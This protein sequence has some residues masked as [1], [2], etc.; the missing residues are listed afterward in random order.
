MTLDEALE[1]HRGGR[2]AQAEACYRRV[3]E[4]QPENVDALHLLG[5]IAYQRGEH[6]QAERLIARALSLNAANAPAHSNLGNV[7]REQGRD[8]EAVAAYRRALALAPDYLEAHLNLGAALVAQDRLEEAASCYRAVQSIAP[9]SPTGHVHLGHIMLRRGAAAEALRCYEK[10]LELGLDSAVLHKNLGN[11]LVALGRAEDAER[12]YAR[13]LELDPDFAA[14]RLARGMTRLMLGDYETGLALLESR[15]DPRAL[16]DPAYEGMQA[17]AARIMQWPRWRGEPLPG[18]TLL[19]WADQGMG[20]SI[21]AMRFLP[22]VKRRTR[23]D[24]LIECP[25]ALERLFLAIPEVREVVPTGVAAAR[26]FDAQCAIMSLPFVLGTRLAT[27]PDRVPYITVPEEDARRWCARLADIPAPRVGLVWAGRRALPRDDLR[28]IP[29]A[30]FA[31][32]FSVPGVSFLSLQ[33]GEGTAAAASAEWRMHDLMNDA[34]DLLDT[35]ALV[36]QLDL[37]ISVDTSVA[38]LAG[39]LGKPVWLLNRFESEWRWMLGREDSPWYPTMR[40][41][42]QDTPGDWDSVMSR[43]AEALRTLVRGHR[44]ARAS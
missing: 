16:D 11:V 38:H 22:E 9:G 39:A 43:V 29:L 13:A 40:I 5:V 37:V 28:S 44:P 31:P 3:L 12:H 23:G 20:D 30:R 36:L 32:L 19:V 42:R 6:Q 18:K 34:H 17:A 7:L 14:A 10:A 27:V 8:A 35:A 24:I 4:E 15:L 26:A 25:P 41:F 1:H 33:K 2:L 21:M